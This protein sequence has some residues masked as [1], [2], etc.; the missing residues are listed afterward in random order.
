MV[1]FNNYDLIILDIGYGNPN[2]DN[3]NA[4]QCGSTLERKK[5]VCPCAQ[6]DWQKGSGIAKEINRWQNLY[7]RHGYTLKNALVTLNAYS[8][9]YTTVKTYL[10]NG[11]TT[12][13][14]ATCLTH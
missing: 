4:N 8:I 6:C 13:N 11:A 9:V 2:Q 3:E 5:R 14:V 1:H 10:G 7:L 12:E